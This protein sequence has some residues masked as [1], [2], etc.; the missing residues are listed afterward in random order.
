[1]TRRNGAYD[2]GT[3]VDIQNGA[4]AS[5]LLATLGKVK[6]SEVHHCDPFVVHFLISHTKN[7]THTQINIYNESTLFIMPPHQTTVPLHIL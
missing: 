6:T 4:S 7:K 3:T 5:H 2:F 1:M